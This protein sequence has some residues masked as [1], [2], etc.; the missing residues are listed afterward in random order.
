MEWFKDLDTWKKVVVCIVGILLLAGIIALI[1]IFVPK[2]TGP[3]E[4]CVFLN[5][6]A[7][8]HNEYYIT[9]TAINS[10]RDFRKTQQ[11][12]SNNIENSLQMIA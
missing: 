10:E 3:E 2:Y 5:E 8:L 11:K 4:N 9:V 1:V 7:N 12:I 6:K